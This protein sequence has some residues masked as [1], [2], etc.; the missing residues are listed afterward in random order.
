MF[1]QIFAGRSPSTQK[2]DHFRKSLRNLYMNGAKNHRKSKKLLSILR[3][4]I[5]DLPPLPPLPPFTF[6]NKE[7]GWQRWQVVNFKEIIRSQSL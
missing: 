7:T 4:Q 6:Y 1:E 3:W 5:W 2:L